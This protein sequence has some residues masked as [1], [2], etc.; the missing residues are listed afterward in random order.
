MP[1]GRPVE[2]PWGF[3]SLCG[4]SPVD[5]AEE[6]T[7][8]AR[9]RVVLAA[10]AIA[11]ARWDRAM[12]LAARHGVLSR[13][14]V[15]AS[16]ERAPAADQARPGDDEAAPPPAAA[17]PEADRARLDLDAKTWEKL[18]RINVHVNRAI[19][20]ASD[21]Q[22]YGVRDWW[23]APLSSGLPPYGDCKDYAL[24]KRRELIRAG[25]PAK[26][27]SLAT[28][29]TAGGEPHAVL[30]VAARQ[31]DYVLDNLDRNIRL[32]SR[33]PY[34]WEARQSPGDPLVWLAVVGA[35]QG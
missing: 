13:P 34:A 26:A 21:L 33:T 5:C 31:G 30:I 35:P 19:R 24:E 29:R 14:A 15:A 32:W 20:P 3:V 11:R 22:V 25:V 18:N 12:Q 6:N 28:A 23:V 2:A 8:Q 7:P 10:R 16:I 1:L 4:R 27:L 9:A 17:G